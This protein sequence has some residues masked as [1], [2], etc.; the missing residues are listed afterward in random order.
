MAGALSQLPKGWFYRNM[1]MKRGE[2]ITTGP[3]LS[4][5]CLVL[6]RGGTG[7]H[8]AIT[9]CVIY[10]VLMYTIPFFFFNRNLKCLGQMLLSFPT[11]Y[12]FLLL[13]P[14]RRSMPERGMSVF[15]AVLTGIQHPGLSL[16]HKARRI[17]SHTNLYWLWGGEESPS[18]QQ[19]HKHSLS[20]QTELFFHLIH[21]HPTGSSS[22][23]AQP[24]VTSRGTEWSEHTCEFIVLRDNSAK[25]DQ[26]SG[27]VR[28]G[29]RLLEVALPDAPV[30]G[31]DRDARSEEEGQSKV[32]DHGPCVEH[33]GVG[34]LEGRLQ[35]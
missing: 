2:G 29:Q 7:L 33:L 1:E 31:S 28:E 4:S 11:A 26:Q 15:T 24:W 10:T 32:R 14:E 17:A 22:S 16:L 5:F 9:A 34:G 8:D 25:G 3:K 6:S 12:R 23:W 35:R 19:L 21:K 18:C 27:E 30:F 13:L 20:P